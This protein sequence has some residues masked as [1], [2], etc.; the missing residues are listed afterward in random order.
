GVATMGF[1]GLVAF[2]LIGPYSYLAGAMAMDFGGARGSALSSGLIDGVGYLGG[3]LAGDAVAR[4]SVRL[5]WQSAFLMLAIVCVACAV[6]AVML[7]RLQA[8]SD[9]S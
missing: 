4:V 2:G 5:G 8:R 7:F 6:C 9:A 3:V 1:T